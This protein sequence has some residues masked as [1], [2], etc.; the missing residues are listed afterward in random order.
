MEPLRILIDVSKLSRN[1]QLI[2]Y[3]LLLKTNKILVVKNEL[4][5]NDP[6]CDTHL[7]EVN[8]VYINDIQQYTQ[9]CF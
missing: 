9:L 6:P 1:C 4:V 3:F 2:Y 8:R 7:S 5:P